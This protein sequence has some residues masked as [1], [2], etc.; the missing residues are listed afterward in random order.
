MK[1]RGGGGLEHGLG[2]IWAGCDPPGRGI[3]ASE[4]NGRLK[5]KRGVVVITTSQDS[6]KVGRQSVGDSQPMRAK[7]FQ[8]DERQP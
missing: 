8:E 2:G 6:C 4:V 7:G 5:E 3:L 1:D